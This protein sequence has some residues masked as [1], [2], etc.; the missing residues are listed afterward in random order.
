M[1][2]FKQKIRDAIET[3]KGKKSERKVKDTAGFIKRTLSKIN[4][5][6]K[7]GLLSRINPPGSKMKRRFNRMASGK[8]GQL[9]IF[10]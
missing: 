8:S 5:K 7:Q 3:M 10:A 2:N 6:T 1:R 9:K 4:T